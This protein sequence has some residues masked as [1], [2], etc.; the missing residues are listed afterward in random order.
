M[1]DRI[2]DLPVDASELSDEE[3]TVI[4]SVFPRAPPR[5]ARE[6]PAPPGSA[7]HAEIKTLLIATALFVILTRDSI[8]SMIVRVFPAADT[9]YYKTA[10]RTV[11]FVALYFLLTH[12][13]V[14]RK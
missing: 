8:D 4:S 2:A 6:E 11:L 14:F 3:N 13:A 7:A 1:G 12:F 10:I 9:W 5:Q